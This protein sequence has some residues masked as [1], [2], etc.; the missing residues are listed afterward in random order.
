MKYILMLFAMTM[1]TA[2]HTQDLVEYSFRVEGACGMCKERIEKNAIEVG[3][4]TTA[5]WNVD[6]KIIVI[7][8]DET[9]TEVST[10][11]WHLSQAGHDNGDYLAPDE[12]YD[13]MHGCCKYRPEVSGPAE[14]TTNSENIEQSGGDNQ[15]QEKHDHVHQA[16]GYIYAMDNGEKIPLIGANIRFEGAS[17]GTTTDLEGYFE[18]DNEGHYEA[19]VISY[20][21]Y[22]DQVIMLEDEFLEVTL[23]DGHQL[24]TVEITY[25]RKTTEVSYVNTINVETI[26]REELCKAA[27]CNLSESFETNPSV[28]VSF[29]DAVTGT[30]QIQ[31]LGLA[32]PYVQITRELLPD[33]RGMNTIFGLNMTPG[34]W[35]ESIQLIKG[36]GSV[37]NG[38]E[39]IA[40]QIN[41]ELK[42][43]EKGELLHVNGFAN[44]GG[45][46]EIN[47]NARLDVSEFISTGL[48]FH[49]KRNQNVHDRN[50]DGFTDMPLESDMVVINRWKF[51]R[52]KSFEGQFGIKLADLNH[53]GGSHDHFAGISE[54][55]DD[56]WQMNS[57]TDRKEAWAKIGYV[58]PDQPDF[59]MG[60]QLSAV[61]HKQRARYGLGDYNSDQQSFYSNLILQ[62]IFKNGNILRTGLTYQKDKLVETV[63]KADRYLRDE[64]TPGAYAEYTIKQ[65]EKWTIIPGLRI[66]HHNNYGTF[67]IPRL[68]AKYNFGERS[69]IRFTGGKGFRTP[70]IF[71]ENM[72][73]FATNRTVRIRGN[74]SRNTPYGLEAE[75]AWNYGLSLTQGFE[76]AERE[77]VLSVDAFRTEFV[78]QIVVD[79]E[80]A[81]EVVFH[82]LDGQSYSNSYQIKVDYELVNNLDVRLAYR[83]FDVKTTY[84]ESLQQKPMVSKHRAFLNMAYKT[85][86]DWHFDATLNW[87]GQMR[88]PDTSI[89]PVQYR[90][91]DYSPAYFLLGGQVSKRWGNKWDVYIG[92]ENILN[93][94]Q[95]DAII[96]S[97]EPFGDFFDGSLV[98]APLFGANFYV[99]FRYNLVSRK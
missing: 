65:G 6:T 50:G 3:K 74:S 94:K 55:H 61:D 48:L 33:V 46:L 27:C 42:K 92:G 78:N 60:L 31:M 1:V 86:N 2:L 75:E 19:I 21:G 54:E 83:V 80:N 51:K 20:V 38:H 96:A 35:I 24:E 57:N 11:K 29:N 64:S 67:V 30:K 82:N 98:W 5:E 76:L 25:R 49:G 56:H 81:R 28:D 69:I 17:E 45:R 39:S 58:N 73:L 95:T 68:H 41:V 10:V 37:V 32:G 59:S 40:G 52:K 44:N 62:N 47:T 93:Y 34:P 70:S 89:N 66:D 77:F 15:T 16:E 63:S 36:T 53:K 9:I 14:Q 7:N 72:G 90:R 18:L 79:W 4:A 43:P 22:E 26:T 13:N 99:G 84:G 91:P 23:A 12:V 97:D 8:I 87:R 85:E 71:A 88:L